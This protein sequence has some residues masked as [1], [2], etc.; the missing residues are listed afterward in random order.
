MRFGYWPGTSNL[1]WEELLSSSKHAAS[2]G[3]DGIWVEDHFMPNAEDTSGDLLEC[4]AVVTALAVAVPDVRIG[5][6][7]CSNTYRHPTLLANIAATVDVI[8][9][10]RLVLGIGAGWQEN[11]HLAY[12]LEFETVGWR[13]QRLEEACELITSMFKQPQTN[14][15]GKHYQLADAPLEPKGAPR[16]LV[17]GGG[18]KRTMKI[19]AKYADEWNVWGLPDRLRQKM[20]VLDG[21]CEDLGR[22]PKS[23]ERSAVAM[24]YVTPEH[25]TPDPDAEGPA[26]MRGT[27]EQIKQM[28]GEYAE[29]GVDEVI[30]PA[31]NLGKGA[32]LLESMDEFINDL[33]KEFH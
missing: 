2:T 31:F 28:L 10:G 11:E 1:Q 5:N 4:W 12:G 30:I 24:V 8:S 3:W 32:Q 23:I 9:G 6:L 15:D 26:L 33:A 13:M 29:A 18:E 21:H 27:A 16:L 14:F 19:A 17:A 25:Y 20:A 7:V 22:D